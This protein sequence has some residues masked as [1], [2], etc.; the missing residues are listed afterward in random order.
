VSLQ[1]PKMLN[2]ILRWWKD[3][4]RPSQVALIAI[5]VLFVSQFFHYNDSHTWGVLSISANWNTVGHYYSDGA[6]SGTGWE[7]HRWAWLMIVILAV[8]HGSDISES[9]HFLR[10]GYWLSLPLIIIAFTPASISTPG[11]KMGFAALCLMLL[12]AIWNLRTK[13][14]APPPPPPPARVDK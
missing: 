14:S 12:A 2:E 4:P 1:F 6:K 11:G 9:R 13:K 3:R 5:A 7:I 10:F 8:L